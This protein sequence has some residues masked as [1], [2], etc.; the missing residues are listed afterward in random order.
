MSIAF[1][2]IKGGV[3]KTSL[4][5]NF[6]LQHD[7]AIVT[8]DLYTQLERALP[9]GKILKVGPG[10]PFPEIPGDAPVAYDLGGYIDPRIIPVLTRVS[11]V[12]V[13]VLD[14]DND[15]QVTAQAIAEIRQH[16]PNLVVVPNRL[17]RDDDAMRI[18]NILVGL[19]VVD[20]KTQFFPIKR[21]KGFSYA[22][23][24]GRSIRQQMADNKLM[25]RAYHAVA[26]QFD[27][28]SRY[29]LQ[30]V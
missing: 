20:A 11:H 2:N 30:P 26:T 28:L 16:N 4:A 27:A 22:M 7:Y 25:N 8:N 12:V 21:S 3:G 1:F 29:L 24:D 9:E 23:R 17:D 19:E 15:I 10:E 5:V 6:A 14:E 18:I 13:P